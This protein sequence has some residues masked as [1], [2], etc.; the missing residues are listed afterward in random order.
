LPVLLYYGLVQGL[1]GM[2]FGGLLTLAGALVSR[3][4]FEKNY[5]DRAEWRRYATVLVA[6]YAC[7]M[8][9][10][11]MFCAALAMVSKAVTQLPY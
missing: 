4:Y 3:F 8:G 5:A 6:G 2:P 10:I 9:L 1:S 7:G 11:G